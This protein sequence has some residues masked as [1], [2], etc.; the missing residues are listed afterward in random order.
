LTA[1]DPTQP[2]S[3][4][5]SV[6]GAYIGSGSSFS[7]NFPGPG[8]YKVCLL[9]KNNKTGEDCEQCI[10]ICVADNGKPREK[11]TG[12]SNAVEAAKSNI[13]IYPNPAGSMLYVEV[14]EE[15]AAN[16]RIALYDMSGKL[17]I[18][19]HKQGQ[20]GDQKISVNTSKLTPGVYSIK[21]VSGVKEYKQ[22]VVIK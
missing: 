5:W 2:A 11:V 9:I 4:D 14:S 15:N 21:V 10:N 19:E 16:I 18:D 12:V 7:Y 20:K 22:T 3:Y 8:S 6:N 1:D 13:N 17:V